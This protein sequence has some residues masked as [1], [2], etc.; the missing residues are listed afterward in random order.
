MAWN[1]NAWSYLWLATGYQ[2]GLV[3]LFNLNFMS[4]SRDLNTLLLAH[5]KSTLDKKAQ[6][7]IVA[8]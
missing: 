7:S 3:R 6:V 4:K 2:N 5:E 1:P 8:T